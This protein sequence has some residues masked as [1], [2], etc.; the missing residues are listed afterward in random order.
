M[1]KFSFVCLVNAADGQDAA[2]SAWHTQEHLPAMVRHG[3]FVRAKRMRLVQPLDTQQ[4]SYR[5]LILYEGEVPDTAQALDALNRAIAAGQ[6]TFSDTL[7]P[8]SWA[9]VYEEIAGACYPA[10]F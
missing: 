7:A 1:G 5:Y 3:G 6:I 4:D 9:A 8:Q 2:F 10:P